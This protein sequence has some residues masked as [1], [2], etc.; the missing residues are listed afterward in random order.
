MYNYVTHPNFQLGGSWLS[1]MASKLPFRKPPPPPPRI[2]PFFFRNNFNKRRPHLPEE[3]G[4]YKRTTD[5]ILD[6]IKNPEGTFNKKFTSDFSK[7]KDLDP[8]GWSIDDVMHT[9]GPLIRRA[10]YNRDLHEF[11]IPINQFSNWEQFHMGTMFPEDILKMKNYDHF[12][13]KRS[14]EY[15]LKQTLKRMEQN[16]NDYLRSRKRNL[17]WLKFI[18]PMFP[19]MMDSPLSN[20]DEE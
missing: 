11:G 5:D 10:Q 1:R 13:W 2:D 7:L 18:P 9:H 17:S 19:L 16:N 8:D 14:P 6:D 12:A 20:F 4:N 3:F 15:N